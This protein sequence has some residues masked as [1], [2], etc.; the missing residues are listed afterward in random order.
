MPIGKA[1]RAKTLKAGLLLCQLPRQYYLLL[2]LALMTLAGGCARPRGWGFPGG[3]GTI[4][5]QKARASVHDPYPLNDI[6]PAVVG[7]RPR[8]FAT[9]RSEA[10]REANLPKQFRNVPPGY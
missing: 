6:G 10:A 7:G 9:P 8:E 4:D 5:R 2:A 3:E 1:T